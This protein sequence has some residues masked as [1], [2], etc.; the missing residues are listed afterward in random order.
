MINT[1]LL[2]YSLTSFDILY[3]NISNA[4]TNIKWDFDFRKKKRN[5]R[6]NNLH[7]YTLIESGF[8]FPDK[9][10]TISNNLDIEDDDNSHCSG[11]SASRYLIFKKDNNI[12]LCLFFCY[13][14]PYY[15]SQ[16]NDIWESSLKLTINRLFKKINIVNYNKDIIISGHS[17]GAALSYYTTTKIFNELLLNK[18]NILASNLYIILYGLGRVPTRLC[19]T[20]KTQ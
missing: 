14:K 5:Y 11:E 7:D 8:I 3:S 2:N 9:A 16:L 19:N 17:A 1:K 4:I 6:Y 18:Y 15:T 10:N 20:F 12:V 13:G